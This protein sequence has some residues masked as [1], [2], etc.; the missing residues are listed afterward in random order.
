M[1][2]DHEYK[3]RKARQAWMLRVAR[4]TDPRE[5]K[6]ADVAEAAGLGRGSGSVVSL[7]EHN[8]TKDGPK[9]S[10]LF[11]LAAYY[12]LPLSVFTEPDHETDEER[13]ATKRRLAIGAVELEQDDWDQGDREPPDDEDGPAAP[14]RRP[15]A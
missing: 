1:P 9:Q 5:P 15:Q 12:G 11:R 3:V 7:W 8:A 4:L 14:P 13:L 2:T 6:L 10:Q